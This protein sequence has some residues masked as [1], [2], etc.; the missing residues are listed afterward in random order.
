MSNP[1]QPNPLPPNSTPFVDNG[2]V[3]QEA[4]TLAYK[5]ISITTYIFDRVAHV[6]QGAKVNYYSL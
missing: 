4:F 5:I 6:V 3:T 1:F 2:L